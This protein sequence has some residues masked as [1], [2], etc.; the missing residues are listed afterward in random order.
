MDRTSVDAKEDPPQYKP[1]RIFLL[2]DPE[3]SNL[4]KELSSAGVSFEQPDL[5]AVQT[6]MGESAESSCFGCLFVVGTIFS[7]TVFMIKFFGT[8][9]LVAGLAGVLI[10]IALFVGTM[11]NVAWLLIGPDGVGVKRESSLS[12]RRWAYPRQFISAISFT[13]CFFDEGDPCYGAELELTTG[14]SVDLFSAGRDRREAQWLV[15]RMHAILDVPVYNRE[16]IRRLYGASP[17]DIV[18]RDTL[19]E[20]APSL[21]GT[22]RVHVPGSEQFDEVIQY[23]SLQEQVAVAEK[24]VFVISV[25][26][27]VRKNGICFCGTG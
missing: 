18:D 12:S 25:R 17:E 21:P 1:K 7:A 6:E 9:A 20:R 14:E 4:K 19:A 16:V 22:V 27:I 3:L 13:K 10:V 11:R 24:R 15:Q 26:Y 8:L 2:K 5:L 23:L